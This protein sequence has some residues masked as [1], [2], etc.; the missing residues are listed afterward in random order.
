M[1][2]SD[3]VLSA[4]RAKGRGFTADDRDALF[5]VHRTFLAG[6]L[7]LWRRLFASEQVEFSVTPYFHPILPLLC[8]L[9]SAHESLPDLRLP[10]ASFRH[11]ADADAQLAVDD[12]GAHGVTHGWRDERGRRDVCIDFNPAL[13]LSNFIPEEARHRLIQ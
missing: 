11:P 12:P 8:D 2:Q 1:L 6:V 5:A 4:L 9:A 10:A 3:P 13:W 7:P